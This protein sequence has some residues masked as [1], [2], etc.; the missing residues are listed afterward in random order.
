[1]ND[2]TM[3]TKREVEIEALNSLSDQ[4][5]VIAMEKEMDA[6][7]EKDEP[8]RRFMLRFMNIARRGAGMPEVAVQ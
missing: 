4:D 5:L 1:M 6:G 2:T 3:K 8:T 7:N